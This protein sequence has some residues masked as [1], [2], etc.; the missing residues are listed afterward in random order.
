MPGFTVKPYVSLETFG[1]QCARRK[2]II[3]YTCFLHRISTTLENPSTVLQEI[4][5]RNMFSS[6]FMSAPTFVF[7]VMTEGLFF[8]A[9]IEFGVLQ[10]VFAQ[11]SMAV[12]FASVDELSESELRPQLLF[13]FRFGQ[14]TWSNF[15]SKARIHASYESYE[16]YESRAHE[17]YESKEGDESRTHESCESKEGDEG[18]SETFQ[19]KKD[20]QKT[21]SEGVLPHLVTLCSI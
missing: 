5:N 2:Y 18:P 9:H 3:Y 15:F 7:F 17:S 20:D 11:T 8:L 13:V 10:P 19:S 4:R 1:F 14:K 16:S 21:T 6:V 12:V